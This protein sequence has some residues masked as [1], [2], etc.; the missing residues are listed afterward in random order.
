MKAGGVLSFNELYAPVIEPGL[1]KKTP[2]CSM[3][4]IS[5]VWPDIK[6]FTPNF[7]ALLY[8]AS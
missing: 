1:I 2:L 6:I 5:W 8:S 4:L 3:T 7:L